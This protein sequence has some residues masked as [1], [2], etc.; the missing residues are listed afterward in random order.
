MIGGMRSKALPK[1]KSDSDCPEF[2]VTR[3]AFERYFDK[4]LPTSTFHDLVSKGKIIPMKQ[5]R[6]FYYLNDSLRRL[7]L[8]EVQE[9]PRPADAPSLEDVVRLAFSMIDPRLFPP[10][11]WLLR[12]ES[13][14]GKDVDHAILIARQHGDFVQSF[15]HIELKLAYFQGVLDS[16]VIEPDSEIDDAK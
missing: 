12:V 9:L 8:R 15:D 1:S 14:D 10:P 5:M 2:I 4:P 3:Q 16:L 7:G 6:G 11:S 13:L